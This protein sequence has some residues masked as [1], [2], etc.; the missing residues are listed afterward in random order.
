M[1]KVKNVAALPDFAL[2][3]DFSDGT[4]GVAPMKEHLTGMLAALKDDALFAR[5]FVEGGAVCWPGDLDIASEFVY[6]L[7]HHLPRPRTL[8]QAKNN[9]LTVSLGEARRLAGKTQ[10]QLSE[11]SGIRQG[12]ISKIESGTVDS[13]LSTIRRY[14]E[15][16][17]GELEVVARFGDKRMRIGG[18]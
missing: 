8:D 17:G 14:V 1:I 10:V 11:A 15:G 6:A 7:A 4:S 5:A 3:L 13:R 16:L 2:A 12:D 18:V 9:E